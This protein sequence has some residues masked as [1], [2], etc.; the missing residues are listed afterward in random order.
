MKKQLFANYNFEFDK[1]EKRILI[2][3]S[4]QV[5]KQLGGDKKFFSEEKAFN[6]IIQKLSSGEEVIKLT[7]D[8]KTRLVNQLQENIKYFNKELTKTWFFK[9]WFY[10][11]ILTQ[12]KSLLENHFKG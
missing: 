4:K 6:S 1:N 3:F 11:S 7:K 10:K 5:L 8:E 9:K 2:N 12:Y